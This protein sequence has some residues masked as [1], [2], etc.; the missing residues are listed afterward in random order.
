M[1]KKETLLVR[2]PDEYHGWRRP[3]HQL[4]QQLYL[5]AWFDKHSRKAKAGAVDAASSQK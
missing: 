1:L 2:M 4:L 5:M 3:S